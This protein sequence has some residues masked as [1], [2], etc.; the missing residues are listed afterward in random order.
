[1]VRRET[2]SICDRPA[3][4]EA[5]PLQKA[6]EVTRAAQLPPGIFLPDNSS[7][8]ETAIRMYLMRSA[9]MSDDEIAGTLGMSKK[10]I[11]GYIYK[12]GKNGWL[13]EFL[14]EPKDI[15]EYQLSHKVIKNLEEALDDNTRNEKTGVP[16]KTAVALKVAEGTIFKKFA[17]APVT[18]SQSTIVGVRVEVVGG[19]RPAMRDGTVQAAPAYV[20]AD[21][22]P[23]A[24]N[25]A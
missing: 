22:M 4:L 7:I 13:K 12:A 6:A 20:D 19:E 10:T 21:V 9:G 15:I 8:R 18:S 5:L 16:V 17:E 11:S 24:D 23:T 25:K 3:P 14:D 2:C 1:M